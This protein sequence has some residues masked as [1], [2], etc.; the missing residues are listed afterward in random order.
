MAWYR[1]IP[2][3]REREARYRAASK[4]IAAPMCDIVKPYDIAAVSRY[5]VVCARYREPVH[6]I[7][8]SVNV[9]PLVVR[10]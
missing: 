5:R 7:V 10:S 4:V 2:R 6:D 3:Y 8:C 1:A 9:I